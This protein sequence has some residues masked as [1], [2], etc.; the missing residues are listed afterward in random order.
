MAASP[1]TFELKEEHRA[2]SKEE[3][4][5][6]LDHEV[7][8]FSKFFETLPGIRG[9]G[10]LNNQERMLVKTYMVQKLQGRF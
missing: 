8:F 9:G 5:S 7:E 10:P 1:V 6:L 4:S 2:K 3:Q